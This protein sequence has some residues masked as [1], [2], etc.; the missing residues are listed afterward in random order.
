MFRLGSILLPAVF[1]LNRAVAAISPGESVFQAHWAVE[2][3][4]DAIRG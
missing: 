2:A 1:G 3:I 4:E